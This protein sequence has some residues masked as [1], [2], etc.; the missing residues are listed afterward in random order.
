VST[1]TQ[2]RAKCYL[3]SEDSRKAFSGEMKNGIEVTE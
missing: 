2:R 3:F 1:G